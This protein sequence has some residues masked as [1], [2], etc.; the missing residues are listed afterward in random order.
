MSTPIIQTS[1]NS[2][3]WSPALNARVD[4]QKYHSGAALLRNFFVDYRGGATTRPG[5]KFIQQAKSNTVRLIPFQ[6]S[7]TVTYM[8]EFGP[9]YIRFYNNGAPVY[10]SATSITA[11]GGGPPIVFTDTAH[12]YANGDWISAGG[13]TY[14][15]AGVT[16]NTFTLTDLFGNAINS[17]PFTLPAPARRV[18]TVTSPYQAADLP[19]IKY[20]QDVNLLFLCHPNYPPQVL[21]L[22]SAVS[23]TLAAMSFVPTIGTPTGVTASSSGGGTFNANYIVT[24]VDADGQE[25]LPSAA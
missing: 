15:V 3:E 10:E 8:L 16:A 4:I 6:A 23:W 5:T 2:G 9:G 7:F 17:N 14:I 21:T 20:A 12:G 25:S 1:F 18:Y 11:A 19:L 22:N 24:A 13:N